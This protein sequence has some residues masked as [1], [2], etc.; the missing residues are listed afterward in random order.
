MSYAKQ[1]EILF[2]WDGESW[3]P[4]GDMLN[5][6]APRYD[7]INRKALVSDVRIKRTIRDFLEGRKEEIFVKEEPYK[8]GLADG[9]RRVKSVAGEAKDIQKAILEKCIDVRA[10]GGVF[11]VEKQTNSLTGPIQFKMSKSVNET[12]IVYIKGTG[13]FASKDGQKNKTFREE[14]ILPYAIFATYGVINALNSEKT[15]LSEE[16]VKKILEGL[17]FGT[18][19]LISRS[20]FGQMPR[21]LLR[22]IYKEPGV[23]IG[24]LDNLIKLNSS[25]VSELEIRSIDDY[26]ID[27]SKIVKLTEIYANKIELIEYICDDCINITP[28]PE[29]WERKSFGI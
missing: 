11:P 19:N 13:A 22:I 29:N 21:F 2:L 20:K 10:F 8:D 14:Y 24:G 25:K 28:L 15:N 16:D 26:S 7:E 27:L 18:K 5:A 12:E 3:N 23:Y 6:N 9:K 17:W 1:S 4:N